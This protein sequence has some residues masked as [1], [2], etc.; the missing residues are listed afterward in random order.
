MPFGALAPMHVDMRA[1]RA[2]PCTRT[3][4]RAHPRPSCIQGT[5][6]FP[7]SGVYQFL[8]NFSMV[9]TAFVWIDGHL[10]CQDGKAYTVAVGNYDNPLPIQP[11]KILPFRAHVMYNGCTTESC[12]NRC[13]PSTIEAVS[14]GCFD[15]SGHQ[16][17]YTALG[18]NA[19][20]S[21]QGA[22]RHAPACDG[23]PPRDRRCASVRL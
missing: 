1:S 19:Q 21:W 15:D 12:R 5:V 18:S 23:R 16:C 17:G 13:D 9:T 11:A 8:C 3:C 6:E 2:R 4:A 14:V 20:N 22:G 10:V 7:S